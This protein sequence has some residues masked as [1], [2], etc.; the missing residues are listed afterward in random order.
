MAY[1]NFFTPCAHPRK[2]IN[3][4]REFLQSA[5][6]LP[7]KIQMKKSNEGFYTLVDGYGVKPA[8]DS[9]LCIGYDTNSLCNVGEWKIPNKEFSSFI[10]KLS[11]NL[12]KGFSNLTLALLHEL[13]HQETKHLIPCTYEIEKMFALAEIDRS[14]C[15]IGNQMYFEL[16]DERKATEWA[17]NWLT[18]AENRRKAKAFEKA[19]FK[20]WRG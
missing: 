1:F 3:L 19:F 15:A 4:M 17:I 2:V 20:A 16:K 12:T 13:G 8:S 7:N 5:T 14:T 10:N 6:S 11:N 9:L 18:K